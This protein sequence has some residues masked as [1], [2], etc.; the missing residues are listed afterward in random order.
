MVAKSANSKEKFSVLKDIEPGTFYDLI[1]KVARRPHDQGDRITLWVTDYTKNPAFYCFPER[2]NSGLAEREGDPYGY[3]SKF[4]NTGNI[5]TAPDA[6]PGQLSLQ[7]TCY[8]P[9]ASAIREEAIDK[10]AWVSIRNV[11]VKYGSNQ[12]NLEG[13]LREDLEYGAKIGITQLDLEELRRK[14]LIPT[15][16]QRLR[17]ALRRNRDYDK[18]RKGLDDSI[19]QAAQA[20]QKRKSVV[21]NDNGFNTENAKTR[22]RKRRMKKQEG[23][24]SISTPEDGYNEHEHHTTLQDAHRRPEID[25]ESS[26]PTLGLNPAGRPSPCHS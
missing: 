23:K 19:V 22:R 4:S 11:Q 18:E 16:D 10:G 3:C 5:T 15:T 2:K 14:E 7:I 1:V 6:I 25:E 26:L 9:H 20:G 24:L 8:E 13:F 12:A 21:A 17:D